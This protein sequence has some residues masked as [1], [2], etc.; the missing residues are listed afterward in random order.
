MCFKIVPSLFVAVVVVVVV[1]L[2]I[3]LLENA[4]FSGNKIN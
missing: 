4:G 1:V 3:C 2:G